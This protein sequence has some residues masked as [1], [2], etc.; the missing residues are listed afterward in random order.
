MKAAKAP[1]REHAMIQSGHREKPA[2]RME[3]RDA[4]LKAALPHVPFDGWTRAALEAAAQDLGMSA[5]DAGRYFPGGIPDLIAHFSDWADRLMQ[6]ALSA[7]DLSG[8]RVRERIALAVRVRLATLERHREAVRRALS[9]LALPPNIPLGLRCLYRSV[10]AIW[11]AVGDRSADFSFYT[12]RAL[13]AGVLSSTVLYW[14]DD[15]SDDSTETW[16]FL[17]RRIDDVMKIPR[18]SGRARQAAERLPNP[19]RFMRSLRS[20]GQ[21]FRRA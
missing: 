13:L 15:D 18:V 16:A 6:D 11:Y 12:K 8:L 19:L 7:E 3:R 4:L 2:T 14:L 21:R 17:D 1:P 20:R 5:A 9:W 10:D